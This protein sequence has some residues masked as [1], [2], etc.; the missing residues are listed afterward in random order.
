M[1]MRADDMQ[2]RL[3]RAR[4]RFSD[5]LLTWLTILLVVLTFVIIPLHASGLFMMQGYGL[6]VVL[7]MAS[8]ILGAPAG[9]GPVIIMVFG[10]ALAVAASV[11]RYID[12]QRFGIFLEATA[13]ITAGAVAGLRCCARGVC[14]RPRHLSPYQWRGPPLF[15]HRSNLRRGL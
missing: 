7:V 8:C 4:A 12:H 13:W 11:L 6:A 14:S 9:F 2:Q 1:R 15:E 5:R 3:A 10:V